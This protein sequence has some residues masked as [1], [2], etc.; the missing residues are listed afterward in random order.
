MDPRVRLALGV[1]MLMATGLLVRTVV[2]PSPSI[3]RQIN[4]AIDRAGAGDRQ[5]AYELLHEVVVARPNHADAWMRTGK[6]L[7]A[8][9]RPLDAAVYLRKAA[10]LDSTS[11]IVQIEHVNGLMRAGFLD[12]AAE[13]AA[14][15]LGTHPRDGGMLYLGSA[16]AAARGDA[17]LASEM[18]RQAVQNHAYQPDRFRWDPLFDPVRNDPGFLQA[19]YDTRAPGSFA[20][21]EHPW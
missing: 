11:A 15:R 13:A 12:Q 4:R 3:G 8:L 5:G 21:E 2:G 6:A 7:A 14:R 19:V 20:T 17:G 9:G 16:L 1:L 10:E 18:Y